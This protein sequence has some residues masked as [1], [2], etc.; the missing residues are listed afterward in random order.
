[1]RIPPVSL[2]TYCGNVHPANDVD[3]WL[4][5]TARF[6]VPIAATQRAAGHEFG[7]GTWFNAKTAAQL[8]GD[9]D[10]LRRAF[11]FL[12][13]HGL[14]IWTLNVFPYG[15]F[16]GSPV[17]E[18]VYEPNWACDE[19]V[20]Y[21]LHAAEVAARLCDEGSLVPM[22]TLPLGYGDVDRDACAANLARVATRLA[23][24][25]AEHD[26][27]MVVALE[28]EPFCVIETVA[29]AADFLEHVFRSGTVAE[30]VLRDHLGVC[31][32]LCHLAVVGEDPALALADLRA[33]GIQCPKIQVSSCLELRDPAGL[34]RLLEFD[35]PGYLHQTGG[36]G[37]A[38]ALDLSEI[39]ARRGEFEAAGTLRT[40]FHMP[41]FWD[42][43]GAA[44]GSTRELLKRALAEMPRPLPL[45]EVETYT[46]GVIP[47]WDKSDEALLDGIGQ[48]LS[49][50]RNAVKD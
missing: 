24:L 14:S 49:F 20:E 37:G 15:E 35:E 33:R 26:V 22:S 30:A 41:V 7:L 12:G 6:S 18:K 25:R 11:D 4:E 48:E 23:A 45:L 8:D 3:S 39:A 46:W 44:L 29:Q 47:G 32:D 16:H 36:E 28:P 34:D 27:H 50:V 31:V 10:E 2:L 17:K 9:G 38:R 19:R 5:L 40:H 43:E 21:T 42:E 13:Q 1:M